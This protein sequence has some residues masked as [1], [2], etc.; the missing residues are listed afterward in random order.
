ME[1]QQMLERLL[2]GQARFEEK[3]DTDRK[4]YQEKMDSNQGC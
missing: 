3:A 1:M 4:A 2:S